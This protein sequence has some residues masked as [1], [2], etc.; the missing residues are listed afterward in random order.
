MVLRAGWR[1]YL[2]FLKYSIPLVLSNSENPLR[3]CP[4]VK[5][6]KH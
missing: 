6:I 5:K 1:I 4:F 2:E 3:L